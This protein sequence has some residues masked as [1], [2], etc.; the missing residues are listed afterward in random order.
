MNDHIAAVIKNRAAHLPVLAFGASAAVAASYLYS[1]L[2]RLGT[3]N[4]G[5]IIESP[6]T[7][8]GQL[9]RNEQERL[10]YPPDVLP[11]RRDVDSPY[12]NIRVYEWGPENGR[13]VLLVHGISTPGIALGSIA[14]EL[15][16]K[17]CRVMLFGRFTI[18]FLPRDGFNFLKDASVRHRCKHAVR[19]LE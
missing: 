5:D 19:I 6:L 3:G 15:V 17:G 10:P 9:P 12:G 2:H 13:R 7:Q 18:H 8:V 16:E 1:Y 14:E 4:S 11:G